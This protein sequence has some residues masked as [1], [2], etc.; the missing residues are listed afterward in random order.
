MH[1]PATF[2]AINE[3]GRQ[4][5]HTVMHVEPTAEPSAGACVL[6]SHLILLITSIICSINDL[7]I[8]LA[9]F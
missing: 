6:C 4:R 7:V 8:D 2:L 9:V 5:R 3:T 1:L